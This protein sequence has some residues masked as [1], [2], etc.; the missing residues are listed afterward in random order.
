M[1]FVVRLYDAYALHEKHN[2]RGSEENS[3]F[4]CFPKFESSACMSSKTLSGRALMN[5]CISLAGFEHEYGSQYQLKC[6]DQLQLQ[7]QSNSPLELY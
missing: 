4:L 6:I 5:S 1:E 2:Y 3:G 7:K